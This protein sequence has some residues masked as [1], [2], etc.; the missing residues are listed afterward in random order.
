MEL[1]VMGQVVTKAIYKN[2]NNE[3]PLLGIKHFDGV[4]NLLLSKQ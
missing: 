2:A 1:D 4:R 3:S